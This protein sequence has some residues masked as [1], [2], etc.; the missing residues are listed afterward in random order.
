[1][2]ERGEGRKE[3]RTETE[4]RAEGSWRKED[5]GQENERRKMKE[6]KRRKKK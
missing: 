1:M 2:E 3:E 6:E 5:E 4:G